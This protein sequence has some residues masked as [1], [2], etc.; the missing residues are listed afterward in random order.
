MTESS[1]AVHIPLEHLV[2][3]MTSALNPFSVEGD[4]VTNDEHSPAADVS[5]DSM[6]RLR[7]PFAAETPD[8]E[9]ADEPA[10]R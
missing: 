3:D 1:A 5:A 6:T 7:T 8:R 2:S 9:P 10:H 4:G